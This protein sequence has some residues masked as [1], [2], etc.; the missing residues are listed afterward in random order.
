MINA[1]PGCLLDDAFVLKSRLH[2]VAL[3]AWVAHQLLH[4]RLPGDV[5]EPRA[6]H[7]RSGEVVFAAPV[8][9]GFL[10]DVASCDVQDVA[11]Q[12][13]AA[14]LDSTRSLPEPLPPKLGSGTRPRSDQRS[15]AL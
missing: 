3:V 4:M 15:S 13:R 5:D 7:R 2:V 6:G 10:G 12:H 14:F 9:Q 1:W 11:I 8:V